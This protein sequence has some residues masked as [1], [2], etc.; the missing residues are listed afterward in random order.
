MPLNVSEGSSLERCEQLGC[1]L[2]TE[3]PS[4]TWKMGQ[5]KNAAPPPALPA[6]ADLGSPIVNLG[7]SSQIK[8][9]FFF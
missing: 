3:E 2:S 6:P 9:N 8:F 1:Q 5:E 7:L 4:N